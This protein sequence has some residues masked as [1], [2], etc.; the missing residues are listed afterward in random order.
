MGKVPCEFLYTANLKRKVQYYDAP[1]VSAISPVTYKCVR[2]CV[3]GGGS[4]G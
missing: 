4:A 1:S 3:G 2:V